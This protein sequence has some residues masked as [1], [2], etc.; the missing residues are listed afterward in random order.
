[1]RT[2]PAS[3]APGAKGKSRSPGLAV[4]ARGAWR[5]GRLLRE[6]RA[7]R[8]PRAASRLSELAPGRL[9]RKRERPEKA[10][11]N[12]R[13]RTSRAGTQRTAWRSQSQRVCIVSK[14]A[15]HA[16]PR[17]GPQLRSS[18]VKMPSGT[19]GAADTKTK[20]AWSECPLRSECVVQR[21]V[22]RYALL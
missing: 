13:G 10:I 12:P 1:M 16:A 3:S 5:K 6:Q 11:R 18:T 14:V 19:E 2:L 17:A 22:L 7:R 4:L 8:A 21:D 20:A 15:L 9:V